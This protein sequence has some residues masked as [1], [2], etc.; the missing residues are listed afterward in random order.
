MWSLRREY[1]VVISNELPPGRAA[2]ELWSRKVLPETQ[3]FLL[4]LA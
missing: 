3:V 4:A 1:F 2:L